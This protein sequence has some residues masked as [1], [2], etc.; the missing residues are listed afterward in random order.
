MLSFSIHGSSENG[1]KLVDSLRLASNLANVGDSKTLVIHP[2]ST[3]HAQLNVDEQALTGVTPG[4]I[5]VCRL[6]LGNPAFADIS[7]NR[8]QLGLRT[9]KISSLISRRLLRL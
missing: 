1:S 5:R 8:F 2:A 6:S 9:S 7:D 3:T 4:L